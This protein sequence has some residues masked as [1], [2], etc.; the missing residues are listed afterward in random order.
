MDAAGDLTIFNGKLTILMA[1]SPGGE[2]DK[3]QLNIL[4]T[5]IEIRDRILCLNST[6]KD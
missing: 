5:E 1:F 3:N 2:L 4:R 6:R